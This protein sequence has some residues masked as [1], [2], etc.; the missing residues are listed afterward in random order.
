MQ[1]IHTDCPG[2]EFEKPDNVILLEVCTSSGLKATQYCREADA[3]T[4]D[5]FIEDS[6]LTPDR[7]C[8]FH[9]SPTP[10]PEPTPDPNADPNSPP[11]EG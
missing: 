9:V 11:P 5:Y 8:T 2:A 4:S 3:A 6:Y 1:R 7:D 10:T